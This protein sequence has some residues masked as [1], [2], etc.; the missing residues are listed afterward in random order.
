MKKV[1]ILFV[2]VLALIPFCSKE[3]EAG[4]IEMPMVGSEALDG[5]EMVVY[6]EFKGDDT[7]IIISK[8]KPAPGLNKIA[9]RESAKRAALLTAYI[10]AKKKF[11]KDFM[12]E[13]EGKLDSFEFKKDFGV[14]R[15]IIKKD[16]LKNLAN[17]EKS[18]E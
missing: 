4:D 7:Y 10:E 2:T 18:F 17:K 6:S 8:G 14:V 5:K 13:K 3:K 15:Y 11:G 1:L 12:P 9:S 16:G